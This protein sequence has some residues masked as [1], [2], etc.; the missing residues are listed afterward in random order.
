[1]GA[2]TA[3]GQRVLEGRLPVDAGGETGGDAVE[4][5]GEEIPAVAFTTDPHEPMARIDRPEE[6]DN[7]AQL[8]HRRALRREIPEP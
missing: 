5:I 4:I 8:G 1:M 3:P 6:I 7:P 2:D